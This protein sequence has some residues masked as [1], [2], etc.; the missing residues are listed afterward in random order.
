MEAA[1]R[2]LEEVE[3]AREERARAVVA[4]DRARDAYL[5]RERH[6]APLREAAR[7]LAGKRAGRARD[8]PVTNPPMHLRASYSYFGEE[9]WPVVTA[10]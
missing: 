6:R 10:S 8:R 3:R 9:P 1:K 4:A 5:L 2:A 7:A